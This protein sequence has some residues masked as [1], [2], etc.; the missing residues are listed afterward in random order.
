MRSVPIV[1]AAVVVALTWPAAARA[2]ADA[3]A[4]GGLAAWVDIFDAQP[5]DRP[6]HTIRRLARRDVRAV[7]VQTSNHRQRSAVHRPAALARRL[8]L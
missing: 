6:A 4:Y 1:V 5:W 8:A 2:E 3:S 7:F